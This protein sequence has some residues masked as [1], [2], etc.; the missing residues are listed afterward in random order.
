MKRLL[1]FC[2]C[3][4]LFLFG[5]AQNLVRNPGFENRFNCPTGQGELFECQNWFN[6]TF[7]SPDYFHSCN[8]ANLVPANI[9][10]YQ[11]PHTDSAYAGF[12]VYSSGSIN[13]RDYIEGELTQP[14]DSG[15]KY[16]FEMYLS[17]CDICQVS[18]G[19][20]GV[21]FSDTLVYTPLDSVGGW[22]L[23]YLPFTPQMEFTAVTDTSG[24]V[25]VQDTFI[26]TGNERYLIIGNF[27]T[28]INTEIDTLFPII[29]GYGSYYYVDDVSV[30]FCDDTTQPPPPV[31]PVSTISVPNIF[32]PNGD[33]VN[34]EF[35]VQT[36][37]IT[38]Y[39]IEI[40]NRWGVKVFSTSLTGQFWDG[41]TISGTECSDGTYY[42]IIS[43][44]GADN[45]LYNLKGFVTLIR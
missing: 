45:K 12:Y 31:E 39:S 4:L 6:P 23:H 8:P 11:F 41:R 18:A 32:T 9:W 44:K 42:Y 3:S 5:N 10:G 34:D 22:Y 30:K 21:Y 2:F 29:N 1:F 20:I 27:R 7:N 38:E 24:W 28:G 25:L 43:A 19:P 36:E 17:L 13:S 40:Y 26:A 33:N 15:K 16:C 35:R 14:L 37:N